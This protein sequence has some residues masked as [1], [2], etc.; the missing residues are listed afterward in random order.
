MKLFLKPIGTTKTF[1]L[2]DENG[3]VLPGQISTKVISRCNAVR[4]VLV[5]FNA[6]GDGQSVIIEGDKDS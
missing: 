2:H 4:T 1:A 6:L 3:E 5:E